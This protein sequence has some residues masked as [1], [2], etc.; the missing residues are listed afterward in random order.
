MSERLSA[1]Y[2]RAWSRLRMLLQ[3]RFI[4]AREVLEQESMGHM[5]AL[6]PIEEVLA[7]MDEE[8]PNPMPGVTPPDPSWVEDGTREKQRLNPP[9]APRCRDCNLKIYGGKGDWWHIT[10]DGRPGKMR[11][12]DGH[13]AYPK[14]VP[15]A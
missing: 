2:G 12:T 7:W 10:P 6:I 9:D 4:L 5:A 13:L 1:D 3:E 14:E 15:G 11:G 8:V